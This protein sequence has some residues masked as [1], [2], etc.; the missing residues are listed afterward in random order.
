MDLIKEVSDQRLAEFYRKLN[1]IKY[2]SNQGQR[3]DL[4]SVVK[5]HKRSPKFFGKKFYDE[6]FFE[7]MF[8]KQVE[9]TKVESVETALGIDDFKKNS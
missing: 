9:R 6:G 7:E 5:E 2:F 1:E 4:H 8:I 3:K